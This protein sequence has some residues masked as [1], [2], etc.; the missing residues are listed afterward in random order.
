MPPALGDTSEPPTVGSFSG[1]RFGRP[2]SSSCFTQFVADPYLLVSEV[3]A[4]DAIEHEEVAV[5]CRGHH[6]LP[7]A[8][9]E[10]RVH[11]HRRLRRV[12][13]VHV[14]RRVW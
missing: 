5:A 13:V 9:V 3:L 12:P 8:P 2:F 1:L 14:V 4:R 7:H 10:R 11:E 6:E